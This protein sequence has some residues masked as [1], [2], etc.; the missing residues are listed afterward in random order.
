M[1][2]VLRFD[3]GTL[4]V[5]YTEAGT[6]PPYWIFDDR[7]RRFRTQALWY[8]HFLSWCSKENFPCA[9]EAKAYSSLPLESAIDYE[10]FDYQKEALR[11]WEK[12]GARGSIVIPTGSGKSILALKAIQKK[13]VTTLVVVPTIDLMHQWYSL[14]LDS[15]RVEVGLLGGGDH[16]LL[17]LTVATY[18]SAY[19]YMGD[20]GNRFG[21]LVFDEVHHLPSPQFSQIAEMSLAPFRLGLTA[22]Y[23]KSDHSEGLL[24][25]LIGPRLYTRSVSELAGTYLS[26]YE[27][28]RIRVPLD[29]REKKEYQEAQEEYHGYVREQG[30]RPYGKGW[31]NLI[32]RSALEAE[33]RRALLARLRAHAVAR[34]ARAKG[35][36]LE[37]ILKRHAKD[38]IL[39]FTA[40]NDTAY[41]ISRL[42]LLPAITHQ[43][44]T[45]ERKA[46]FDRFRQGVYQAIVTSKVLNEGIDVPD[47]NVA[48]ILGGNASPREHVQRLGR[49]L[50]KREGKEAVLYEVVAQGTVEASTSLRRRKSD[51]YKQSR[52]VSA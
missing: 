33:G 31:G 50:R 9:D 18:E 42:F 41:E 17:P 26:A 30:I 4:V 21:L 51:A 44:P 49:I 15:F 38:R 22:T 35:K 32:K 5:S 2:P 48:V 46:I 34:G 20:Y 11:I 37:S 3:Q 19:L 36:V 25:R 29:D 24:D 12:R 1:S 47:A 39:I 10:L 45:R 52:S 28:V 14:L 16:N 7:T 6:L 43:T 13:A 27:T 23:E 40:E 8:Q